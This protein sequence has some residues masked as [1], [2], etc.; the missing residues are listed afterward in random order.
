LLAPAEPAQAAPVGLAEEYRAMALIA[1]GE[2]ESSTFRLEA[3]EEHLEPALALARAADLPFL[4]LTALA[5]LAYLVEMRA[6]FRLAVDHSTEAIRLARR[7]GWADEPITGLAYGV[8]ALGTLMQGRVAEAEPWL[9]RAERTVRVEARPAAGALIHITRGM[10]ELARGHPDEAIVA[11]RA[12]ERAADGLFAPQPFARPPRALCLQTLVLMGQAERVERDFAEME[13]EER[14]TAEMRTAFAVLRLAQDD[15]EAAREALQPILDGSIV[16]GNARL[17]LLRA[18]ITEAKACDA[19]GDAGAAER[20]LERALD[21]AEPDGMLMPFT[22]V[23]ELLE[24]HR[25]HRTSHASLVSDI[26]SMLAGKS[27]A[28]PLDTPRPL[29]EPLTESEIRVLRY[30]PTNLSAPE[31]AGELYLAVSTVKTHIQHIYAKL[32]THRRGDAVQR[33]RTLGLLAPSSVRRS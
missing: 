14:E 13:S 33:A 24:R 25:R 27:P 12:S 17:G 29:R 7:H 19:L 2:A 5:E 1:L 15:A 11:F 18:L 4:E 9:A 21:I 23:P 26:L 16:A 31:I 28:A 32:G 8:L 22:A 10:L 6:S 3:A 20:A 30:L